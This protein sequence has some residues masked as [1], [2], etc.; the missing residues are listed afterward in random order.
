MRIGINIDSQFGDMTGIQ[1]YTDSLIDGLYQLESRHDLTAFASYL[2]ALDVVEEAARR[3]PGTFAWRGLPQAR[4]DLPTRTSALLPP[5]FQ[6]KHPWLAV[7]VQA[8]E[9]RIFR[10]LPGSA[11][12]RARQYDVFH[13]PD[14]YDMRFETYGPRHEVATLYDIATR[15][16][17]WAYPAWAIALWERYW[18]WARDRCGVMVAISESTRHDASESLNISLDRIFVTPLAARVSTRHMPDSPERRELLDKWDLGGEPF[19][20]YSG[21]LEPRK[22]LDALVRA[23]AAVAKQDPT[24]PH[25]L[26]FAGGNW[27]RLDLDLRLQ[28]CEEGIGG[29]LIT[30]GYVTNEELNALMSA[31]DA[32]VYVSQYEGFGLPPLEAMTCGAP[33]VV[34]N[35][36][37]LPEVVGET[38]I[39]V[40]PKD[41]EAIAAALYRL[42]T[43]RAENARQRTLSRARA[44]EFSWKRTAELTMRAYEAAAAG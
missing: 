33:V 39:Q 15:A 1:H 16:C 37:S 36:S 10:R 19:V 13:A 43:D 27:N 22:N 34:S 35:T 32:F 20:L 12:H 7:Q 8:R 41:E 2:P 21:T 24:I 4:F 42:L 5:G 26:V 28:S 14:P 31:C 17:A 11:M 3:N 40:S 6:L 30:T 25:K 38:G 29:R 9:E 23:F 44:R 18:K